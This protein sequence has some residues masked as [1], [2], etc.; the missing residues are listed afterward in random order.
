[1]ARQKKSDT[2]MYSADDLIFVAGWCSNKLRDDARL[3][4][5]SMNDILV[6]VRMFVAPEVKEAISFPDYTPTGTMKGRT[7]KK[8]LKPEY[9]VTS[10]KVERS[11]KA[12]GL[13]LK[14]GKLELGYI[15][16]TVTL[17]EQQYPVVR[18]V[19]KYEPRQYSMLTL[20]RVKV[21]E[22]IGR[23]WRERGFWRLAGEHYDG[24]VDFIAVHGKNE[25]RQATFVPANYRRA[26][27]LE[28]A[29]KERQNNLVGQQKR[30]RIASVPIAIRFERAK[31]LKYRL[32][33]QASEA[34]MAGKM[35]RY[36]ALDNRA[37]SVANWLAHIAKVNP[38]L[39]LVKLTETVDNISTRKRLADKNALLTGRSAPRVDKIAAAKLRAA[40]V[41]R[42]ES[43]KSGRRAWK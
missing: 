27:K 41:A 35:D 26:M 21:F 34:F 6:K 4:A 17:S 33:A 11:V 12:T 25:P 20:L 3:D 29:R 40:R 36:D 32:D 15:R 37:N 39:S 28:I 5:Q 9:P 22:K 43:F 19:Q 31:Q 7:D 24:R 16:K 10:F 13:T 23:F 18:E 1:M 42:Q 30:Y 8:W 38:G 14:V 2:V